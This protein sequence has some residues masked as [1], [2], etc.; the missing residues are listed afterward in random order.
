MMVTRAIDMAKTRAPL[1]NQ[2]YRQPG[3]VSQLHGSPVSDSGPAQEKLGRKAHAKRPAIS[4]P[5]PH[6]AAMSV[7]SHAYL[8]GRY[9]RKTAVSSTRF[10][11]APKA[12]MEIKAPSA[13]QLGEAPAMIVKM[14]LIRRE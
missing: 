12:E 14:L 2:T 13:I 7:R 10:P 4:W 5:T 1:A 3:L 8:D 11:P 6:Q 9:S